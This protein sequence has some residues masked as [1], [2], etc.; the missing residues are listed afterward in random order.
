MKALVYEGNH[1]LAVRDVD[2]PLVDSGDALIRVHSVGICGSDL[3]AYHGRDERRPP[4]LVLGHEVSGYRIDGG[5]STPVVVNPLVTC[6]HCVACERGEENLCPD[7][8]IISMPPRPGA[9]SELFAIPEKNVIE[10]PVSIDLKRAALAEPIACGWHAVRLV[11]RI[12]YQNPSDQRL[13]VIGGGAV[14]LG[15]AL[16]C[17]ALGVEPIKVVENNPGRRQTVIAAGFDCIDSSEALGSISSDVDSIIDAVGIRPTREL[18]CQMLKPG[19]CLVHIGLGDADAGIDVRR[20]TLQ[21]LRVTGSYTYTMKDFHET[22]QAMT[23]GQ[24]GELNWFEEAPL[25]DGLDC[26][27]R[28][29]RGQVNVPKILLTP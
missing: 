9:F 28:L 5:Q 14:G 12:S 23:R 26:F 22:V 27:E 3:H 25:D 20:M 13:V 10:L 24:L 17:R 21:E 8:Q 6:G 18:A 19:G 7:R 11:E 2:E 16:S 15:T 29:S 1:S 4:P